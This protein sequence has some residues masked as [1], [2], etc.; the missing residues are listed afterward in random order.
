MAARK[1]A[2]DGNGASL[3]LST[4]SLPD[5]RTESQLPRA[6]NCSHLW[7]ERFNKPLADLFD[8]QHDIVARLA[9]AL[10]AQLIT[11]EAHARNRRHLV[12]P[13]CG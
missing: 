10:N 3:H 13:S 12:R 11:A 7:V 4:V 6:I 8:M 9:G 5:L 2:E 1:R